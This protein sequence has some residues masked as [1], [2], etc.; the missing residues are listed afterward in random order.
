[1]ADHLFEDS[2]LAALY[3]LFAPADKR[4]DFQFYLPRI[5]AADSVLDIGCGTGALL[6][7]AR[8]QGHSGHLVGIDPAIGMIEQA[9]KSSDIEW[10]HGSPLSTTITERFDLVVMTGHTFQV[11]IDDRELIDTLTKIREILTD[12]G[13]FIFE[14]RN[15]LVRAWEQWDVEYSGQV[16]DSEGS[17][18]HGV[19]E[20]EVPVEGDLVNFSHTFSSA[21]W[22]KPEVSHSSLRFLDIESLEAL[23][24]EAGLVTTDRFGDWDQSALTD[25]SLEIISVTRR[26]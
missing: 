23:L 6:H 24:N 4:A 8:T 16:V 15:P 11:L 18:V 25:E 14:T 3:D 22:R 2:N 5:M 7:M 21:N 26:A 20:V 10:I 1:M 13:K 17:V 19:C 9:R 12:D